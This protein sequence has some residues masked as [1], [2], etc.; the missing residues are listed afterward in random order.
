MGKKEKENRGNN[1]LKVSE[2]WHEVTW[3]WKG[4]VKKRPSLLFL[5]NSSSSFKTQ[6]QVTSQMKPYQTVLS[7]PIPYLKCLGTLFISFF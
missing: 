6:L 7:C 3:H 5:A 4:V 2:D 1:S